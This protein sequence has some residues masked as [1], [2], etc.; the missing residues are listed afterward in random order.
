MSG[1]LRIGFGYA[2]PLST[3]LVVG[4]RALGEAPTGEWTWP[5]QTDWVP[6]HPSSRPLT[7][8]ALHIPGPLSPVP[9]QLA[10]TSAA[11][12]LFPEANPAAIT[13]RERS[14]QTS[15]ELG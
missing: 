4:A 2:S 10:D 5:R 11:G 13:P 15:V 3:R 12:Y 9:H 7:P 14:V 6:P 8:P 1:G